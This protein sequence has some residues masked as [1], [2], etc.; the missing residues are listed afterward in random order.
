M[1]SISWVARGSGWAQDLAAQHHRRWP[2]TH[3]WSSLV[4]LRTTTALAFLPAAA[5]GCL[6][7]SAEIKELC[8]EFLGEAFHAPLLTDQHYIALRLK[9]HLKTAQTLFLHSAMFG[10]LLTSKKPTGSFEPLACWWYMVWLPLQQIDMLQTWIYNR[11]QIDY[12]DL[13]IAHGTAP[14]GSKNVGSKDM[15]KFIFTLL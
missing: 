3:L 12:G 13:V 5:F 15:I 2:L 8:W 14:A 11:S 10:S 9:L 4:S 1:R 6:E 7:E